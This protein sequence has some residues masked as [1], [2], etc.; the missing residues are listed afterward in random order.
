VLAVAFY[1]D[2]QK[3]ISGSKDGSAIIW[4]V[5]IEQLLVTAER[6]IQRQPSR[7]SRD[8]RLRFALE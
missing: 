7:F 6:L 3:V 4:A 2:G 5:A 1:P 8:E